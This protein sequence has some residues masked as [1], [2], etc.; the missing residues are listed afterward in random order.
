MTAGA[1]SPVS[2][3]NSRRAACSGVSPGSIVPPGTWMP[4]SGKSGSRK[5]SS[6]P[7]QVA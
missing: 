4:Y 3:R 7:R 5:T 1:T 2:S 6:F